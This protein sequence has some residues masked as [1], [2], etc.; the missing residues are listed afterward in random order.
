MARPTPTQWRSIRTMWEASPNPGLSWMVKAGGGPWDVSTEAIRRRKNAEGWRKHGPARGGADADVGCWADGAATPGAH[1]PPARV[2]ALLEV[3]GQ[4]A[5][6]MRDALLAQHRADWAAARRLLDEAVRGGDPAAFRNG[7]VL[8]ETLKLVQAGER[9]VH[10]F[11]YAALD[12]ASMSEEELQAVV[13]G[14]W[15]RKPR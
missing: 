13:A 1:G 9:E 11:D 4:S 12:F 7:R 14:K 8:A 2:F 3:P 15:P 6:D 5:E 10:C